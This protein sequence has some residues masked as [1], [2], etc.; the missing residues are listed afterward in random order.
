[1]SQQA[2]LS[3]MRDMPRYDAVIVGA[4]FSG[5]Y[6]IYR[7]RKLGLSV[8][9]FETADDVGGTWYWNRYPGARCDVESLQYSYSFSEDLQQE[10]EW[11]ERY[12]A[13]PEI[14]KYI[15]HVAERFDL[16]RAIQF[17]TRVASANYN[18]RAGRWLVRTESGDEVD[19]QFCIMATGA[20]SASRT[21]DFPGLA[22]FGGKIYHTG[23]WP[24]EKVDFTGQR[25]GVIGTGSSGIQAIPMI[26]AEAAHLHVFQRTPNYSIPA[27]NMPLTE[28]VQRDW[29]S[30]YSEMRAKAR[31]A[32][33][34]FVAEYGTKSAL[35]VS[36]EERQAEFERRWAIGGPT[37]NASYTDILR[38]VEANETAATFVRGQIQSIVKD[39]VVADLLTPKD[40]PI[41]A[42]RICVDTNYYETFNRDNVT[43]VDVR[44]APVERLTEKGLRTS[45]AEY[46]FDSIVFATG[47]D[48]MTGPLTRIDIRG[49]EGWL[50][51]D[52]WAE[53]ARTYLGLMIAGFPNMFIVTGPGSPSVLSNM[54]LAL[55][56]H[57]EWITDCIAHMR[58]NGNAVVEATAEAE[59]NW[60]KQVNEAADRT[61]FPLA[62]SWYVGA[63]IPGKPRVF[64][65]FAG[66]VGNYIRICQEIVDDGYRGFLMSTPES[67]DSVE[68]DAAVG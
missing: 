11:T 19:C 43:L 36:E 30:R 12:S 25:V 16:R 65:P 57:V 64:L 24:H 50:L 14:L 58:A 49:R 2:G 27:Q 18:E 41:G 40:Y 9:C 20:L 63:N 33:S 53:G 15:E 59:N 44:S 46:E 31:E 6:L 35:E 55:E 22:D 21:P 37:F 38:N 7:L 32:N 1:M 47:F 4:G 39:P 52:K 26:A 54:V 34:G 23:T 29:K 68:A 13:Q 51:K 10:W 8:I 3:E 62:N 42:K 45:V 61:L 60:V 66:G 5:L 17:N 67:G 56:H 28:E 48:A